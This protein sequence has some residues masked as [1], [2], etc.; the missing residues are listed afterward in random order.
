MP[1][2]GRHLKKRGFSFLYKV[3]WII[4]LCLSLCASHVLNKR[5]PPSHFEIDSSSHFLVCSKSLV[6]FD[7]GYCTNWSEP[8]QT[9]FL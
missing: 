3:M 7:L 2:P 4:I 9:Q 1:S 5:E 6:H 8:A